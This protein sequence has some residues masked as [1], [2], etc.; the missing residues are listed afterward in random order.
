MNKTGCQNQENKKPRKCLAL[1][2]FYFERF[3]V[4]DYPKNITGQQSTNYQTSQITNQ[5]YP[6]Y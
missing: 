1:S 4:C 3:A 5:F 2:W 6:R